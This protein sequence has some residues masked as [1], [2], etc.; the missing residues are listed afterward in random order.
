MT[1]EHNNIL[2]LVEAEGSSNAWLGCEIS[3]DDINWL[4]GNSFMMA[5]N[6]NQL[7]ECLFFG[8]DS[9]ELSSGVECYSNQGNRNSPKKHG[10]LNFRYIPGIKAYK[11]AKRKTS[12]CNHVT[13][14]VTPNLSGSRR[15]AKVWMNKIMQV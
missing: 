13:A 12:A 5:L 3:K 9:P 10:K 2:G 4:D 11:C 14:L 15:I 7:L 1:L 8:I 6:N